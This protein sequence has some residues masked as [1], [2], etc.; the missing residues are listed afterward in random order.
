MGHGVD[1]S[2]RRRTTL[3]RMPV[4]APRRGVWVVALLTLTLVMGGSAPASARVVVGSPPYEGAAWT[5]PVAGIRVVTNPFRAPPQPWAAGHRGMDVLA[6]PEAEVSAPEAGVVAFVGTVVD[7]PL[8]TIAHE[9]GLVTTLE[10]VSSE[11]SPGDL[12]A[13]GEVVGTL[14]SGGHSAPG[15]LHLGVRWHGVY[16]NP[17]LFYGGVARA[18]LLP[19]CAE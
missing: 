9:D 8:L 5:W 6:D 16:I 4:V 10:P 14:A 19:C 7:R 2:P 12:V 17:M 3:G 1:F 15:T 13:A 18:V 11:L